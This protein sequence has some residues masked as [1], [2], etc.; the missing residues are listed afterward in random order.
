MNATNRPHGNPLFH[1]VVLQLI[2]TPHF[3]QVQ[4]Y[5][6][7]LTGAITPV[8]KYLQTW[9]IVFCSSVN[10]CLLMVRPNK[11]KPKGYMRPL[12]V[13]GGY[14]HA[15]HCSRTRRSWVRIPAG[16]S[17]DSSGCRRRDWT[18]A[19][20]CCHRFCSSAYRLEKERSPLCRR[21]TEA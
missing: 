15:L 13:P 14:P 17:I 16:L 19:D 4:S 6:F 20:T 1:N 5:R 10:A 21:K 9:F 7:F 3:S 18:L 8:R 12:T 2:G 11:T